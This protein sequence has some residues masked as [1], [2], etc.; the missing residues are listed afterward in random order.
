MSFSDSRPIGI[1]DSGVGGLSV[2]KELRELLPKEN[3]IYIGDT[4][5]MPYGDR[6]PSEIK[7]YTI[8]CFEKLKAENVKAAV[9]ACSTSTSYSLDEL[10]EKFDFP[11]I[12]VIGAGA[13]ET[14]MS[15]EN[16]NVLLLDTNATV[17]SGIYEKTIAKIDS[18]INLISQGCPDLV[19]AVEEG[20]GESVVGFSIAKKY[21][22]IYDDFDYDTLILG[23]THFGLV[24]ENIENILKEVGKNAKIVNPAYSTAVQLSRILEEFRILNSEGESKVKYFVS[25]DGENFKNMIVDFLK[26]PR[27]SINI[28]KLEVTV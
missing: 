21:I 2:L 23:C 20:Y 18:K 4:L 5:R 7:D 25:G 12:G 28:E 3:Y 6:E 11:I 1:F 19:K 8:E 27:D 14:I 22:D 24:E 15:T 10:K 26:E 17:K 16:K 9:L 13:L